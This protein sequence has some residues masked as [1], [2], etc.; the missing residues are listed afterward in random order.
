MLWQE[1][2]DYGFDLVGGY[3]ESPPPGYETPL[4]QQLNQ[5]QTFDPANA[6]ELR[7]FLASKSA[8]VVVVDQA[9]P[10]PGTAVLQALDLHPQAVDGVLVARLGEP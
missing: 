8:T 1:E 7:S 2:A 5:G 3:V 9:D 10:G 6:K 4:I